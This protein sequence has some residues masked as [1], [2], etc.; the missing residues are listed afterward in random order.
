MFE[1]MKRRVRGFL[2]EEFL[3]FMADARKLVV[4]HAVKQERNKLKEYR[5]EKEI[6]FQQQMLRTNEL[7]MKIIELEKRVDD[8]VRDI[9]VANLVVE[10]LATELELSPGAEAQHRAEARAE[11]GEAP[12]DK[13]AADLQDFVMSLGERNEN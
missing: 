5:R 9:K 3:S 11:I 4:D 12:V 7:A 8:K 6:E 2:L 10:R 1:A 13:G